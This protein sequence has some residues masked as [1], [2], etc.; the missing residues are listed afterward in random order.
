M[1]ASNAYEAA[2]R[3]RPQAH[4]LALRLRDAGAAD[5]VIC[6]YLGIEPEGLASCW[7]WPNGNSRPN[8]AG[9]ELA[10]NLV[11]AGNFPRFGGRREAGASILSVP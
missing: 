1:N 8:S 5:E 6:K 10:P 11:A 9:V 2:L 4:S 7:N 3:R